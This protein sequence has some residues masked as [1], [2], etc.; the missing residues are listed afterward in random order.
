MRA[1]DARE[2]DAQARAQ[3]RRARAYQQQAGGCAAAAVLIVASWLGVFV[4]LG[5]FLRWWQT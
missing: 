2:I 1:D 3:N 4:L 5:S